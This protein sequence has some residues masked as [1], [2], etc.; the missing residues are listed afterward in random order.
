MSKY[1]HL[2]KPAER[3]I[4]FNED[5]DLSA[6]EMELPDCPPI[7]EIEGY[8]LHPSDQFWRHKP[9]PPKLLALQNQKTYKNDPG[10]A[11][12]KPKLFTPRLKCLH[13]EKNAAYYQDEIE[14][15]LTEWKRREEGYWFFN[16][17]VPTHITGDNYYYLQVWTI[18]D[19]PVRYRNRDRKWFWFWWMVDNDDQCY[20]LNYPKQRREGATTRVCC[21]RVNRASNNRNYKTGLQSKDD[22]HAAA[23]H[24]ENILQPL[25]N[26]PFYFMP[27]IGN[28]QNEIS[29]L[30]FASP[31]SQAHPD[32]GE[33]GLN[34]L[35]DYRD[36]STKAYDGL[37][38]W[39]IHNDEIAKCLEINTLVL[40]H[41]G[42]KKFVQDVVP[43]DLL[44]GPDSLPRKVLSITSGEDEMYRVIPKKGEPWGCNQHHILSL[45]S[46]YSRAINGVPKWGT[47][48]ISVKDF[49]ALEKTKQSHLMQYRAGVEFREKHVWEPYYVGFWL[50]NGIK[51][52]GHVIINETHSGV[53][54]EINRFAIRNSYQYNSIKESG[55]YRIGF[56]AGPK[57]MLNKLGLLTKEHIPQDY[58]VNSRKNRL[59][60]LAGLIDSDGYKN[61]GGYEIAQKRKAIADAIV[62]VA[63]SLGYSAVMHIKKGGYTRK[64]GTRFTAD[65]FKIHIYG[66]SLDEIPVRC[67]YKKLSPHSTHKNRRNPCNVGIKLA[68]KGR[69]T[70]YGFTLDGDHL[71]LLGDFTVTHNTT[72]VDVETRW[73]IQKPCLTNLDPDRPVKGKAINT[74]TVDEMDSGGGRQFKAICDGSHYFDRPANNE[75]TTGLYNLF[76][77]ASEGMEGFL[78][79]TENNE[80]PIP[81]YDKYGNCDSVAVER[82]LLNRRE[83]YRRQGKIREYIEECRLYP[84]T[85]SDCWKSSGKLCNFNLLILE[86][87]MEYYRNGNTDKVRGNFVWT[88][89]RDS[90]V[91][92][93]PSEAGKF[94]LSWNFPNPAQANRFHLDLEGRK[95]PSNKHMF[96]AGADPYNFKLTKHKKHSNGA[97]AVFYKYD[98]KVD[99]GTD[100][101]EWKSNR[102]ICTYDH[103]ELSKEAF[104]EEMIK[105]CVYFGCELNPEINVPF[106]WDYFSERGY[107]AY[108]YYKFD[109]TTGK[110]SIQPGSHT[111]TKTK[112]ELFADT[113][114]YIEQ[115]GHR[116]QHDEL[117]KQWKEVEEDLG[118][119]DLMVAA[120]KA[121]EAARQHG[122]NDI[123]EHTEHDLNE[124]IDTYDI[125]NLST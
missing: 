36:S 119:Y 19:R 90:T 33:Q 50:G 102:F 84:L 13:I 107:G 124:Y 29:E 58:L 24:D 74:S 39:L 41:N 97:G 16:N 88:N 85:W 15:I 9:L 86:E 69:G 80:K 27:M 34:S 75:T 20:G 110:L 72:T 59:E 35:I 54:E 61:K 28:R 109:P 115:H 57:A 21:I 87:R 77:P 113:Q 73:Q 48:N 60:F 117:L 30:K 43:G 12:E 89:G 46:C 111:G 23:V 1:R 3:T 51:S 22:D 98:H 66:N 94:Y 45:K 125:T 121:L 10:N 65:Y 8:G 40:M 92:F 2:Y 106:L 112:E 100:M 93:E 6:I 5:K 95:V 82:Y 103:R 38:R 118:D 17:G 56:G 42:T 76:I 78:P 62:Y 63:Q 123:D 108:L 64:D 37:K 116:E 49:L 81:F 99:G 11:D 68:H 122:F 44:M 67:A 18:D 25:K 7:E 26:V 4:I 120:G 52:T 14:F 32:Y 96:V 53:F 101:H 104:G 105:M 83:N 31:E 114:S 55:C 79:G 71:F 47:L 91:R 70:Y